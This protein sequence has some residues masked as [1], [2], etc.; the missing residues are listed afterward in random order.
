MYTRFPRACLA[1]CNASFKCSGA[2][3]SPIPSSRLRDPTL[4]HSSQTFFNFPCAAFLAWTTA[5]HVSS[6]ISE[7]IGAILSLVTAS[8]TLVQVTPSRGVVP[9]ASPGFDASISLN[10]MLAPDLGPFQV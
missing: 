9:T 2:L 10:V 5:S 8:R 6:D 1:S 3:V 4:F 7:I